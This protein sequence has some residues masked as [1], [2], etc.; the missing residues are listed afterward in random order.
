MEGLF[1]W[2]SKLAWLL[3]APDSL[4]VML[5]VVGSFL[6]W[7]NQ[8]K[9]AKRVLSLLVM[10][11]LVIGLFPVG[12][13]VLYPLESQYKANPELT[14]VD[15]IVVLGGAEQAELSHYWKQPAVNAAAE[16]FFASVDLHRRYPNAQLVFTGGS[17]AMLGQAYKGADVAYQLYQNQGVDV[18]KIIFERDSRNTIENALL[19]KR[20]VKPK[21]GEQWILIT[22]A[23]HMPRSMGIFCQSDWSVIPYPVDFTSLPERLVRIDWGFSKHLANLTVGMKEWVGILAYKVMGKSC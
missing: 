11:V 10:S 9:W 3:I 22:T 23:W 13:W 8:L 1:Y 16:R 21:A 18:S 5:L 12:E 7:R 2:V 17:G 15:G 4:M 19:S 14:S 20:L 6:L